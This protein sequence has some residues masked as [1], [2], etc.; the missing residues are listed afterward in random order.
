MLF[1]TVQERKPMEKPD[2]QKSEN[3]QLDKTEDSAE[4]NQLSL[5]LEQIEQAKLEWEA[6][7]DS[8]AQLI[9]LLDR[10]G[11]I[12]R[13]NRT[14]ERWDLER[15]TEVQGLT[16]HQLLHDQCPHTACYWEPF[17]ERAWNNLLQ[18][19]ITDLEFRD[20]VLNR[21]IRIQLRPVNVYEENNFHRKV[22][23]NVKPGTSFAS[24]VIDDISEQKLV[25]EAMLRTQKLESMGIMAG[26]VA[27][28]FNNLLTGILT[29][30]TLALM[31]LPENTSAR[32]NIEKAMQA[33]ERAADVTRQLLA[34][35][36]K[37]HFRT[38]LVNLN[39][40]IR[41][42]M[43]FLNAAI[44]PN[45][46]IEANLEPDIKP[47]Q[48]DAGQIQ[49]I[50]MNLILNASESYE[51]N[52]GVVTISTNTEILNAHYETR[53]GQKLPPGEYICLKVSDFGRGIK[54]HILSQIF[55]PFFT[56]KFTG[57]G[58]GLAAVLGIVRAHRGDIQVISNQKAGTVF[59]VYLPVD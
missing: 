18:N 34:Y 43:S 59:K 50:V 13:A 35:S 23:E 57:R 21:H 49:Q 28:D 58:L 47:I 17:W 39:D 37:G 2:K 55:D 27:H 8:L 53:Y 20:T 4:Q 32:G 9:C 26:G 7:V 44:D 38:N 25:E 40:L 33:G 42:N 11:L 51:G 15:V 1:M 54:E 19:Q 3:S 36:G 16:M 46:E 30:C 22:S 41:E 52:P 56:T 12:L 6:A 14:V 31:K 45:V 5:L 24:L 10:D 48:A 29:E